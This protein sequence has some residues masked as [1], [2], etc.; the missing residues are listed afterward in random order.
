M[1]KFKFKRARISDST[2]LER[3]IIKSST[4]INNSYYSDKEIVAALGTV[5]TVDKQ[6][7]NDETYWVAENGDGKIIGCGGWSKRKILYGK[8]ATIN[9]DTQELIPG[10]DPAKIRAF[11]V[12]PKYVRNGIGRKLLKI[13]EKEAKK[14]GYKSL[15]LV[16]TL[17]GEKLYETVGFSEIKRQKIESKKGVYSETVTMFKNLE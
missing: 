17:S 1:I 4:E 8:E 3:L 10:I 16:A 6:L 2:N 15:E 12:H 7:I 14:A 11:F 5:W 9:S 13:C